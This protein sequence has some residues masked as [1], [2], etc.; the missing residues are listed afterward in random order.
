MT[1]KFLE[2]VAN[3]TEMNPIGHRFPIMRE[4]S[5]YWIISYHGEWERKVM[6]S[7]GRIAGNKATAMKFAVAQDPEPVTVT[8]K[9]GRGRPSTGH[10]M[11]PAQK[12]AAYRARQAEKNVTVTFNR[13][14]LSTLKTI[15]ANA[16]GDFPV[17]HLDALARAVFD[18]AL[19]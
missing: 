9:R 13:D 3:P 15:L 8:E 12:Q 18:A 11:T 16:S 1:V 17:H 6:K 19:K 14:H 4:N 2:I 10:A 7:T 5:Q